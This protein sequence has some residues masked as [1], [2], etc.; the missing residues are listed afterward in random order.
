MANEKKT[1][2]LKRWIQTLCGWLDGKLFSLDSERAGS[3]SVPLWWT[4]IASFVTGLAMA[5]ISFVTKHGEGKTIM[6]VV[7]AAGGAAVLA[8]I[9][10][11][12]LKDLPAFGSTGKKIGRAAYVVLLCGVTSVLGLYLSELLM[13]GIIGAFVLWVVYTVAFKDATIT[14]RTIRLDNGET[15][16]DE[17]G[18]CGEHYYTDSAGNEYEKVSGGFQRKS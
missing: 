12:L 13:I 14:P 18:V 7:L 5:V 6:A 8:I 2:F 15:L 3:V 9:V 11:F 16:K 10:F 17:R 4:L 1:I